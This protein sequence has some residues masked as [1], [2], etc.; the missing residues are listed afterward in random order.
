MRIGRSEPDFARADGKVYAG[1]NVKSQR[2]RVRLDEIPLLGCKGGW[3]EEHVVAKVG[4]SRRV[5]E[6]DLK[7]WLRTIGQKFLFYP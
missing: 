3:K 4:T 2:H 7:P 6:S 5:S 1:S